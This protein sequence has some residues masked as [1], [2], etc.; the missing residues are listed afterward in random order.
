MF[1]F[2]VGG[3][4]GVM[5]AYI[6][7][8]NVAKYRAAMISWISIAIGISTTFMPRELLVKSSSAQMTPIHISFS[9][10]TRSDG[11]VDSQI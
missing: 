3:Y 10:H 4:S 2:S 8:F 5:Y 1:L 9:F 6:G 7:E 11:T